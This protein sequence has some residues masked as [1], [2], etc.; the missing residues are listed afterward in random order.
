MYGLVWLGSSLCESESRL[1]SLTSFLHIAYHQTSFGYSNAGAILSDYSPPKDA[2][3]IC[4]VG[5][6]VGT[7]MTHFLQHYP[8]MKGIVF[9]QPSVSKR[10]KT[11]LQVRN[12]E[13]HLL[14]VD[15]MQLVVTF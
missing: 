15:P 7:L 13:Y 4:D 9:D 3:L 8:E 2:A 10:A 1:N 5:G 12:K 11:Y 14:Q 6:G